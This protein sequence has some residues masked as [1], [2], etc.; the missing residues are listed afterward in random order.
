METIGFSALEKTFLNKLSRSD[1]ISEKYGYAAQ[2]LLLFFMDLFTLFWV[3]MNFIQKQKD[4]VQ[5]LAKTRV[6]FRV[7]D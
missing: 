5:K 1:T 6:D 7:L 3:W 2:I 4:V